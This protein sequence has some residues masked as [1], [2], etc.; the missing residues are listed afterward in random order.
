MIDLQSF[1]TCLKVS[2]IKLLVSNLDGNWQKL[3]LFN[4]QSYGVKE[5]NFSE[6]K[7]KGSCCEG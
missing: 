6:R 2:C 7:A 3:L 1:N 5:F 4:L